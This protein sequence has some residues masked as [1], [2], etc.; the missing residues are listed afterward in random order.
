MQGPVDT[1]IPGKL[2]TLSEKLGNIETTV[3]DASTRDPE[4]PSDKPSDKVDVKG[5]SHIRR[6]FTG[7]FNVFSFIYFV[8]NI[9]MLSLG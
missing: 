1:G 8:V 9:Y 3:G 4:V 7:T 2:E 6:N 5:G